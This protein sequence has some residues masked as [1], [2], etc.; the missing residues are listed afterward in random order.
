M[1]GRKNP[2][3]G[4]LSIGTE[5]TKGNELTLAAFKLCQKTGPEFHRQR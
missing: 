3:V 2:R 1:L 4:I 5:D